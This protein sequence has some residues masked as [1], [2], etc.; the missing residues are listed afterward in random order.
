M[1]EWY[2]ASTY[3]TD[4]FVIFLRAYFENHPCLLCSQ[5][6]Q[7]YIH[8]YV[9]RL[10][11]DPTTE[12]NVE[13]VICVIICYIAKEEGKQYTKRMLPPFV[14]PEC[15]ITLEHTFRMVDEMP[16]G[17][18]DYR[19]AGT[20]L[21]T[22]CYRTIRRHYRMIVVYTEVA[23]SFLAEYLA[24]I[25]PFIRAPGQPPYERLFSLFLSLRQAVDQA[26]YQRSGKPCDSPSALLYLHP[27]YVSS[28]SR[29]TGSEKNLLH[30]ES[31][32]RF[33]FD[34]S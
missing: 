2:Q 19:Y 5:I 29:G 13:I 21:G 12:K 26:Y 25:A 34:S 31:R 4:G 3:T 10:I 7:L 32:I 8:Y 28:K 15:N 23:V 9:G 18:I 6:H 33:Y 22:F 17:R 16:E 30:L 24:L 14:T 27:V 1:P 20:F 11:R